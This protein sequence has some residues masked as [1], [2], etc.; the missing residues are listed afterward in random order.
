MDI[1]ILENQLLIMKVLLESVQN[2]V[3]KQDLKHQII[4]TEARIK[5]LKS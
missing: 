1:T 5:N 3:L 2:D 4:F